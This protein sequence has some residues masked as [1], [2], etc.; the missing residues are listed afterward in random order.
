MNGESE[1]SSTPGMTACPLARWR[2]PLLAVA[3][4]AAGCV[5]LSKPAAVETCASQGNCSDQPLFNK[6]GDAGLSDADGSVADMGVDSFD[7]R[8]ADDPRS[9]PRNIPDDLAPDIVMADTAVGPEVARDLPGEPDR[10]DVGPDGTAEQRPDVQ[11]TGP[12]DLAPD[13]P[14]PDLAKPDLGSD[15]R[16]ADLPGGADVTASSCSIFYGAQPASGTAGHP[17]AP[18]STK[19]FCVVTCDAIA[20]WN[21]SNFTGRTVTVNGTAVKCGDAI[22]GSNAVTVFEVSA[23]GL[24][25]ASLYWWGTWAT[26]CDPPAGSY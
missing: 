11:D 17:P 26:S 4:L 10:R 14:S 2:S 12:A 23:G 18:N 13:V 5:S 15:P 8:P 24:S 3:L 7:Q 6:G 1:G 19:A 22:P 20:G 21:C 25:Y 9:D 16:P